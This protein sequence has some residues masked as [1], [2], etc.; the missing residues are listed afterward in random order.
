MRQRPGGDGK[1]ELKGRSLVLLRLHPDPAAVALDDS[2]TQ[3]ETDSRAGEF[4]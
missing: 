2:L 3:S 1:S 4:A